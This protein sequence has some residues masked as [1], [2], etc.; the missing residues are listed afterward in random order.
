MRIVKNVVLGLGALL[1]AATAFGQGI[2]TGT[3]AGTVADPSAA[4]IVGAQLQLESSSSGLA[5]QGKSIA[6]GTFKFFDVPI[7]VYKVVINDSGFSSQTVK[8]VLVQA[9]ATTNLGIVTLHVGTA[10]QVEVNG[11]AAALLE[12]TDS[13]VTTTFSS[14]T[15]Q[16]IPL[17]NGFD[18]VAEVVPGVV[19]TGGRTYGDNFSNNSGDNFS[20]NGQSGRYNNFEIDGQDNNDNSIGGPASFFGSQDAIE[21]IQVITN[22]YSAQYGRNAGAVV[23]YITKSGANTFHG[24]AFEFYQGQFLSSF[25][26]YEKSSQFGFC[27]PG[28]S[29][30]TGCEE[31]ALPRF[32]ENRYGGTLG[33]AIIKNKLFFFGSTY[34]DPVRTGQ[35]PSQS[36]P[37][38]TPDP[39]GLKQLQA[40][41]PGNPGVAALI[42]FGPYAVSQGNPKSIASSVTTEQVTGPGG[43]TANIEVSS[44]ERNIIS[45]SNDQEELGRLDWQ[46]DSKDHMFLRYF[47]Q[48]ELFTGVAGTSGTASGDFVNVPSTTNSVG[49]DWIHTFSPRVVDQLRYSFADSKV[50]FEGG[51]YPNCVAT[52]FGACPTQVNFVGTNDDLDFGGD[53][54][55][56]QGRT[57]KVTQVQNNATVTRGSQTLL[58]GGEFDYQNSPNAGLFFC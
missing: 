18:T 44:V 53:I 51:A 11:A 34:W 25:A 29:P 46:P 19:S 42:A 49:A 26:D 58:I 43:Q 56:P 48:P 5:L 32:V 41:F 20:V 13:Q 16:S 17:N 50:Y 54:N 8:N 52:N 55:F 3:V 14:E 23:N 15:L 57:I 38:L 24:S 30:T 1:F 35:T 6:D 4:V 7:G 10:E 33:G 31:P 47:Y 22:D 9:G 12:T 2:T 21:E 28:V 37:L 39:T 27:P 40:A 45:I 36:S